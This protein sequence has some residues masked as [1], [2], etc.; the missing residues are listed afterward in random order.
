MRSAYMEWVKTQTAGVKF[1]LANSGL[2]SYALKDLGVDF[3]GFGLSGPGAYGYPPLKAAIAAKEGVGEECVT[4]A[5]GTSG[6]NWLAMAATIEAG[7]EVVME[8]PGYS[9]MW[10][11]AEYLGAS[12]KF[13]ERR[14]DKNFELDLDAMQDAITVKTR[15]IVLTN[16]HN[17]SC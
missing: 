7:D 10:E 2:M 15:L 5:L 4:T 9:L 8:H 3:S 12:V 1:N 6:A 17:P 11:T 13:V 16:L 14:A